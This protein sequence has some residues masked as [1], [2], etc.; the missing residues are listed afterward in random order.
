[1]RT[2]SIAGRRG[3][4]G[5]MRCGWGGGCPSSSSTGRRPL[6]LV[7][8]WTGNF[9]GIISA[10]PWKMREKKSYQSSPHVDNVR[11]RF[12]FK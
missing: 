12:T 8:G 2:R 11:V 3:V 6:L 7:T 1:M 4:G 10:I 9:R 5:A